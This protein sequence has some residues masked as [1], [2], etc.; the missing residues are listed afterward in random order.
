MTFAGRECPAKPFDLALAGR[1]QR[2]LKLNVE[3]AGANTTSVHR[4]EHLDIADGIE[5]EASRDAAFHKLDDPSNR[6]LGIF[7]LD[8]I[9]VAFGV[10]LARIS[11][12]TAA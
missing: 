10:G 7:R 9:E 8:E 6:A 3:G 2:G 12:T 4:A 1:I 11:H 5:P